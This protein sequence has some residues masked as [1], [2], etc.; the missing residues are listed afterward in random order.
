MTPH[1]ASQ[2]DQ[3]WHIVAFG[4]IISMLSA[5]VRFSVGPFMS[6]I[7]ADFGFSRTFMSGVVAMGMLLYGFGMPVAGRLADRWGTQVVLAGGG[8]LLSAS[9][10]LTAWTRSPAMFA[11]AFGL[12]ASL[13][14][15]AASQ[16]VMSP[17]VS[18]AFDRHRGLAMTALAAGSMGGIAVMT[19]LSAALVQ[20]L[21]WRNTY[22]MFAGLFLVLIVPG[23]L[24]FMKAP[25][26]AAGGY[27][28][29]VAP[30][31][32]APGRSWRAALYTRSF[33]FL[34]FSFFGCGFSMNL[35]SAHGVPML[36]HHGYTKMT[37]AYGIGLIGLVSIFGSI[38]MGAASDRL[39]RRSFLAL[40]YVVRGLGFLGLM[41][42]GYEWELYAVGAVGGLVWAGSSALTSAITADLYG[43]E[44]VGTLF[45]VIYVG[46]QIGASVGAYLG[47]WGFQ[48]FGTYSLAF[49]AAAAL[50]FVSAWLA[51]RLPARIAPASAQAEA[52]A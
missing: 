26:P 37:A 18:R 20:A 45:G 13:G 28:G 39:G 23:A 6:P 33:W 27:V 14:F 46:H 34:F 30:R 2:L 8:V 19:P 4:F 5:G 35:L 42:V 11:F 12:V 40:I 38:A 50:L 47:G 16:V 9:L 43:V 51:S 52:S 29:T 1:P 36:E 21:G 15:A 49:G 48:T 44:S 3:A 22:F 31:P 10:A 24:L 32:Q 7:L 25:A 41:Y 17:A